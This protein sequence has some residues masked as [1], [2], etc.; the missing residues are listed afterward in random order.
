[1]ASPRFAAVQMLTCM[2]IHR[3]WEEVL[4]SSQTLKNV[5]VL[6]I[7]RK[8][9]SPSVI[10][11]ALNLCPPVSK[12][13]SKKSCQQLQL[14]ACTIIPV[15]WA[16][17]LHQT[18]TLIPTTLELFQKLQ[19]VSVL[20]TNPTNDR[21]STPLTHILHLLHYHIHSRITFLRIKVNPNQRESLICLHLQ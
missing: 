10:K 7:E 4:K 8:K 1:M 2:L 13:V 17:P 3:F 15:Q 5:K 6:L 18:K 19:V 11:A 14:A 12:P 20:N 16:H 9:S 21:T